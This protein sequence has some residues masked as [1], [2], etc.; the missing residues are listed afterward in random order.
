MSMVTVL[1]SMT[2]AASLTLAAVYLLI[3]LG[4][5]RQV[6]CLAFSVLGV[7]IAGFAGL[8]LALMYAADSAEYARLS[9]WIQLPTWLMIAGLVFFTR[10]HLKAGRMWLGW[11]II[12]LRTAALVV[13]FAGTGS[14]T[15]P[16]GTGLREVMLLGERVV[17]PA[18]AWTPWLVLLHSAVL[19]L[20]VFLIDAS[21]TVWRRGER[22]AA[23]VVG[24]S[25]S[26]FALQ[27]LAQVL[28]VLWGVLAFPLGISFG[29]L[30]VLMVMGVE[31]SQK[32][33][34]GMEAT[35][36]LQ[37]AEQRTTMAAN[38][39]EVGFWSWDVKHERIW[40]SD[41][42]RAHLGGRDGQ[43]VS[44]R[45][46]VEGL[47]PDQRDLVQRTIDRARFDGGEHQ[48]EYAIVDEGGQTR[49]IAARVTGD[50]SG[51]DGVVVRGVT[52]D[53]TGRKTADARF[54][55]TIEASPTAVLLVNHGG[56]IELANT[57]AEALFGY[58]HGELTGQSVDVLVPTAQRAMHR[59]HRERFA[60]SPAARPMG[61]GRELEGR[62]KDGTEFPLEA[63]LTPIETGRGPL[64][65]CSVVDITLRRKAESE[66]AQLREGLSHAGRVSM[67]GQLASALAHELSQPLG[68]IQRNAEAAE[69]VLGKS[70]TDLEEL[71]AIVTDI[72][73]DD[74]RAG[75][76]IDR[77]RGMLRH[78]QVDLRPLRATEVLS[79]AVA[80]V[81]T[82][83]D[84]AGVKL[85]TEIVPETLGLMGDR[86]AVQQVVLNLLFNAIHAVR[87]QP[88]E[89]RLVLV[90]AEADGDGGARLSVVDRGCGVPPDR[91]TAVF[92]PFVTTK[93]DGLGMGLAISRT[94]VEAHGGKIWAEP[95]P[96]G[97]ATF[98]CTLRAAP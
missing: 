63:G 57:K 18:A 67:M 30:L 76:V 38:L 32:I 13:N 60:A 73:R 46:F 6:A 25:A 40:A 84:G 78:R 86:I 43:P 72:Q 11:T 7:G 36:R 35:V 21:V 64:V 14:I 58:G 39:T 5:R 75:A 19:L 55:L 65:L 92:Q 22:W 61:A 50:R 66:I 89:R 28:L 69:L 8:E 70:P 96:G 42:A 56:V 90:R 62:R 41:R 23:V 88:A 54:M 17:I 16:A 80:V 34:G 49:W 52:M 82:Y 4:A 91:L 83:A 1:W 79:D 33:R 87:A 2:A 37:R 29:S 27:G 93:A 95:T 15:F 47:R 10:T 26:L 53:I 71:R 48:V 12:G 85:A 3:W 20:V 31:L 9:R 45:R 51:E 94:I 81:R 77:I 44:M 59:T 97:G 98:H 24:G 74:R 68:A